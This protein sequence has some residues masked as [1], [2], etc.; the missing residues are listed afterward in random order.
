LRQKLRL[1]ITVVCISLLSVVAPPQTNGGTADSP[2]ASPQVV[3]RE[4]RDSHIRQIEREQ[5]KARN[6]QR[7]QDL[8]KDTDKLLQLATDLKLAVDRSSD[9][10]LSLDVLKKAEQVEKLSKSIQKKMKGE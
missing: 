2:D 5:E 3:T 1:A 10:T 6:K 9:Q 7:N 4:E 8:K